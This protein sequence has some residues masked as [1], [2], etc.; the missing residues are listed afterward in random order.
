VIVLKKLTARHRGQDITLVTHE[1][2]AGRHAL[3][4][5]AEDGVSVLLACIAGEA[6]AKRGSIAVLG[7]PPSLQRGRVAWIPL[8]VKL[9]DVL[10]VDETIAVARS[11]RKNAPVEARAVLAPLGLEALAK[12]RVDT[13]DASEVRAVALAEALASPSVSVLLIEEPFVSMAAPAANALAKTLAGRKNTCVVVSTASASDAALLADDFLVFDR[14][15][16]ATVASDARFL[17]GGAS[18]ETPRLR[19]VAEDTRALAA[20]LAKKTEITRLEL[21]SHAAGSGSLLVEGDDALALATAVNAAI[22]D[23]RANVQSIDAE[24]AS[25]EALR[26]TPAKTPPQQPLPTPQPR[27]P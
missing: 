1:L 23:A 21:A 16:L 4:G 24:P 12:R 5:R 10:R 11:I 3:L 8:G 25:L 13:L 9:P 22:V 27:L 6:R 17:S 20:E 18:R 26:K 19:I 15:K 7:G 2:R 14:G